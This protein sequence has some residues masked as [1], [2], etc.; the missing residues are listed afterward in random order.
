MAGKHKFRPLGAIDG[1]YTYSFTPTSLG[2]VVKVNEFWASDE[3]FYKVAAKPPRSN[4]V[5]DVSKLLSVGV[6]ICDVHTA[7]GDSLKNWK[8]EYPA[9]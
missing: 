4:C 8:P 2:V 3:E 6:K 9:T 7:L 1:S 5:M